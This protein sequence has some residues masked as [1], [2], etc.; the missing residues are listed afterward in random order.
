MLRE[1]SMLYKYS[2]ID[3][4]EEF[5]TVYIINDEISKKARMLD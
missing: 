5:S 1:K 4:L 3:L 2:S